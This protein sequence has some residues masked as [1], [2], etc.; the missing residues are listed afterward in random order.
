ME[1]MPE[2]VVF[3]A[4]GI[5]VCVI[6]L[7][8]YFRHGVRIVIGS[9]LVVFSTVQTWMLH[10]EMNAEYYTGHEYLVY[11]LALTVWLGWSSA[12]LNLGLHKSLEPK[13]E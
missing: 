7:M 8:N 6:A 10:K 1:M 9:A 3:I 5:A 11:G 13:A 4:I 2:T 12:V